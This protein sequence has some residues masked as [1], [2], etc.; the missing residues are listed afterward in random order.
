MSM[1]EEA[2]QPRSRLSAA[3]ALARTHVV[4]ITFCPDSSVM[5]RQFE[6]LNDEG[7]KV[8]LVDNH[9]PMQDDVIA[10]AVAHSFEYVALDRNLGVAGAQNVAIEKVRSLNGE[11]VVLLDQDSIPEAGA[12]KALIDGLLTAPDGPRVAAI[13]SSY[14]LPSGN[15]GSSFVRFAWFRFSK[16]YCEHGGAEL[17]EVDFLI[18]S[19][20]LIPMSVLADVGPMSD[21]LFIDHVD[22]EW[23]LRARSRGYRAY[24]SCLARM[25]HGLGERVVRVWLGRWRTVPVHKGFRY[26]FTFRNSIWL[27]RQKYAPF[28]WITA[29]LIR[30]LYIFVFSGLFLS[31]RAENLKHIF[32]GVRDGFGNPADWDSSAVVQ[33]AIDAGRDRS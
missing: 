13:G 6:R 9:S 18:S 33:T 3:A 32:Q 15:P 1:I 14:T 28:K 31:S 16:I 26:Y 10:A 21:E 29:D 5:A 30:L 7:V 22:T 24:G 23:F 12:F 11:Y 2:R 20:T 17:H 25:S 27:Y 4:V 8:V 19:G